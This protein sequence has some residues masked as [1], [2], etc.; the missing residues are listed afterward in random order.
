MTKYSQIKALGLLGSYILLLLGLPVAGVFLKGES[1]AHYLEFPPR[2]EYL[3]HAQFS[4]PAFVLLG[5]AILLFL[6]PFLRLFFRPA[7]DSNDGCSS[8]VCKRFP[9]WGWV[10]LFSGGIGWLLAWSRFEWFASLQKFTFSLHWL[11]YIVVVNALTYRRTGRSMLTH[12]RRYFL[13]LFPLSSLFWWLFEYLNRFVENWSYLGVD[14]FS[15]GEYF[16]FASLPFATV[17]PAILGTRDL[18]TSF[19][20][21]GSGLNSF[22][23]LKI[24]TKKWFAWLLLLLSCG[25]LAGVAIWPNVLFPTL[26]VAP[27]LILL[28]LSVIANLRFKTILELSAGRWRVVCLT[29]LAALICG[30]FWELWNFYSLAKWCYSVP[31]VGRFQIFEMPLLGYAGYL[32]F[33]LEAALVGELLI[34]LKRDS[35]RIDAH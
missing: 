31:F 5:I 6:I 1:L 17:L 18:L 32:P 16:I 25:A 12:R 4:W 13:F 24:L 7:F 20:R 11:A 33:G 27:L 26:W 29:A 15:A 8:P 22:I 23:S 35:W 34:H 14:E 21:L 28:A 30:F 9:W 19:P 3:E 2:T 10:G